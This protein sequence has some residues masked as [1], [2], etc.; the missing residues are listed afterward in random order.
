M[1]LFHPRLSF[2]AGTAQLTSALLLVAAAAYCLYG[3]LAH[4]VG[5]AEPPAG[6]AGVALCAGS[7]YLL[8]GAVIH[9]QIGHRLRTANRGVNWSAFAVLIANVLVMAAIGHAV[10]GE[11]KSTVLTHN[12]YPLAAI[13]FTAAGLSCV[14]VLLG[15]WAVRWLRGNGNTPT[16]PDRLVLEWPW[17]S[18]HGI[19][20]IAVI[21]I[22]QWVP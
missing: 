17:W 3:G 19:A 14:L 1:N 7:G 20:S 15:L 2:L 16:V 22:W 21:S 6:L 11:S 12:T 13:L 4:P 10:L 18:L 9:W 5:N 8:T